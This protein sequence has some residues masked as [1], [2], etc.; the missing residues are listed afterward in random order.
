MAFKDL[1]TGFGGKLRV[2]NS[3]E[4]RRHLSLAQKVVATLT[5]VITIVG[6]LYSMYLFMRPAPTPDK[7]RVEA[8]IEDEKTLAPLVLATVDILSTDKVLIATLVT[9]SRGRVSYDLKDGRYI[10]RVTASGYSGPPREIQVTS[11]QYSQITMRLKTSAAQALQDSV[12]R[13]FKK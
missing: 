9:D 7:G 6:A 5:G 10:M 1:T 11:G 4:F 2:G 12:K 3:R 13:V 8:V